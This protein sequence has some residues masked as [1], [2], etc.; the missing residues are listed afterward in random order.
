MAPDITNHGWA[1]A[2]MVSIVWMDLPPA[3]Y[4]VLENVHCKHKSGC[5]NKRCSCFKENFHCMDLCHSEGCANHSGSR[6]E[7]SENE[8]EGYKM[9]KMKLKTIVRA[10]MIME[11]IEGCEDDVAGCGSGSKSDVVGGRSSIES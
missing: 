8:A 9:Q 1:V 7:D 3:T 6:D 5:S 10:I 2:N 11:T 4:G